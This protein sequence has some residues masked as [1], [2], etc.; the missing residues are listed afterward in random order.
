MNTVLWL[1]NFVFFQIISV[2]DSLK[3]LELGWNTSSIPQSKNYTHL[4]NRIA[5]NCRNLTDIEL[6][7][8]NE[9]RHTC[10]SLLLTENITLRS[11]KLHI[12][13]LD[14]ENEHAGDEDFAA[15]ECID[16]MTWN[17]SY[18]EIQMIETT[19]ALKDICQF[20]KGVCLQICCYVYPSEYCLDVELVMSCNGSSKAHIMNTF[21]NKVSQLNQTL[22]TN[23]VKRKL[24]LKISEP[25]PGL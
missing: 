12:M 11:I 18:L 15:N 5:E 8:H 13:D 21:N 2:H 20:P 10:L 3:R 19:N 14:V 23:L 25:W 22:D 7:A 4:L 24:N 1:N 9:F 16:V 6:Y 17:Q